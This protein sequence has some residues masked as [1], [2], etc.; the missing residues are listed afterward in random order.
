MIT[1]AQNNRTTTYFRDYAINEIKVA[2]R[3]MEYLAPDDR[4]SYDLDTD[5]LDLLLSRRFEDAWNRIE[6]EIIIKDLGCSAGYEAFKD[7]AIKLMEYLLPI[8]RDNIKSQKEKRRI[9]LLDE[10]S[11]LE[12]EMNE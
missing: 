9:E 4:K 12:G 8:Y 3:I 6:N 11:K 2:Y 1:F 10:L 5:T 7:N